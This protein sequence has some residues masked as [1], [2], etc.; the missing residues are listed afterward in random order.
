MNIAVVDDEEAI[1]EQIGGFIK[2]RNPDFDISVFDMGEGLLAAGKDFDIIFLDIQMEGM[3]GIEAAR[4]LRQSGV[5]AV[6]IFITGIREYVFEAFDVSAFHYLLK[7]IEE[8]KFMEVLG[9]AAEEAGKRKG[10]KERQIFIRAKNQGYTLNLNSILY[11]ESRGKKVEIHTTDMEDII[12]SYATMDELEG[13]LG[14]GFYRCHRGYLVNMAHIA[15]YDSDSIFL[16]SGEK[17]YL[18]RKKHNEFVKAYMWY[19]QNGG[20]SCV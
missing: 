9:R 11:I 7:P 18:T 2:K 17:V 13:Q 10:Q 4:T 1:R 6:V 8:Q 14:D 12:E 19:L 15:R 16:S 5:D 3:G 20:V